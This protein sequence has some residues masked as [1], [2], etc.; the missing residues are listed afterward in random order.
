[1]N[2]N[3]TS[4]VDIYYFMGVR[5]QI[6]IVCGYVVGSGMLEMVN[7]PKTRH[8]KKGELDHH[9]NKRFTADTLNLKYSELRRINLDY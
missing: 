1:M 4:I 2:I 3:F 5:H 8:W 9:N 6:S 7:H